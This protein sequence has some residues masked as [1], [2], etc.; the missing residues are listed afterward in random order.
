MGWRYTL[1]DLADAAG[2]A[3]DARETEFDAVSTDTRTITPGSVFF[4]LPGERFDAH[5]FVHDAFAKGAVAA[6]VSKRCEVPGPQIV[7]G[8]T[9][10]ALQRFAAWHRS[11]FAI[12]L[13]AITGSAG[14]T[15]TKDMTA[16]VLESKYTVAWTQGNLN[17][18]IGCPLSLL[19]I[20]A[21][22]DIALIEMGANHM[23]EI[24]RL[25]TIARPTESAI[26]LIAPAH[27]EGFGSI[28]NVAQAKGEIMEGLPAGGVFYA[29]MAD[30]R[31]AEIARRC[32]VRTVEVGP[33]GAVRLLSAERLADGDLELE[34][35]PIGAIRLPLVSK[36]H[37]ANVLLAVA[38]G[39]EHGISDFQTPLRKAAVN[40][41]RFKVEKIGPLTVLDDSYNANPASMKA[42]LDTLAEYGTGRRTAVLGDMLE[43][44]GESARY[45]REVG[46]H[47]GK[48]GIEAVIAR[49]RYAHDTISGAQAAGAAQS[50]A[51][52]DYDVIARE[53][54]AGARDGDVL[55]VKGSRG[56]AMEK[57]IAAIR[58]LLDNQAT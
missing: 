50:M 34:I 49:G 26:T 43:M 41:R 12:P 10:D 7:V 14:K 51:S 45:H 53:V 20:D 36:A 35:A 25:C 9:L 17:N 18:E 40:A 47:A 57:V 38:I 56:M 52:D 46:E 33:G 3:A 37:A 24:A 44:G 48:L 1:G 27:L 31:C 8:D 5:A 29:N 28:E 55:L 4:A 22:T 42:A 15:T 19:R 54:L 39:L 2:G 21:S 58:N 16:A 13:I 11:K 32:P 23:G 6:V 30:P